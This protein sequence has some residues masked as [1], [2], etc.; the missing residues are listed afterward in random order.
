VVE[1]T[2]P[3]HYPRYNGKDEQESAGRRAVEA[4]LSRV[5]R[6][7]GDDVN[8]FPSGRP[9]EIDGRYTY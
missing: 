6:T 9:E 8:Q 1:L 2:G 3:R 5:P 7:P 4:V